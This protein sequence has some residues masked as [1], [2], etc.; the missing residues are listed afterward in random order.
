MK[1]VRF[2][3]NMFRLPAKVFRGGR[4]CTRQLKWCPRRPNL[5]R[6]RDSTNRTNKWHAR[7][8]HENPQTAPTQFARIVKPRQDSLRQRKLRQYDLQE[9]AKY[10]PIRSRLICKFIK[11]MLAINLLNGPSTT[12][13][14]NLQ[15]TFQDRFR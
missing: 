12:I 2:A 7:K 3:A 15:N 5:R 1:F 9:P 4:R 11:I 8:F 10:I 13:Y 6:S 14:A